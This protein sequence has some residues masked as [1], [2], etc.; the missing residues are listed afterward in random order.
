[1]DPRTQDVIE[2]MGLFFE[3]DGLPRIAGRVLGYLLLR[4][5][6]SSLD[7]LAEALQVSKSSVSTDARM[8][9]RMGTVERVTIPGDRRDY[10]RIAANLPHR[11]AAIWRERLTGTRQLLEDALETPAG[12]VEAVRR[13]L[14]RGARLMAGLAVAVEE[15]GRVLRED[16][17]GWNEDSRSTGVA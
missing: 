6:P 1:M 13:R 4:P 7:E 9:E 14:R 3:K 10:Y 5:E 15:A 8:L 16:A 17:E 2:R 11:M 12:E